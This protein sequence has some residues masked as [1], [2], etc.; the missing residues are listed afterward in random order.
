MTL[1]VPFVWDKTPPQEFVSLLRSALP[2]DDYLSTFELV[3]EP[4]EPEAPVQRWMLWQDLSEKATAERIRREHPTTVGLTEP[5]PRNGAWWDAKMG[6]FRQQGGRLARTDRL[7]WERYQRTGRYGQRWWVIQGP[8]GGHRYALS[9]V[10]KRILRSNTGNK[11]HDVPFAGD[12]PYADPDYRV[13]RHICEMQQVAVWHRMAAYGDAMEARLDAQEAR[14]VEA[15]R[16]K[17]WDW[18]VGQLGG[19]Y[20]EHMGLMKDALKQVGYDKHTTAAV[21]TDGDKLRDD[22]IHD[23]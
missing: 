16:A 19:I 5:H 11:V 3:W 22:F 10:E 4:G 17:M 7:T 15:S 9:S 23:A 6:G 18:L 14:A 20:G 8:D 2:A 1:T 13:I 21:P 12:L